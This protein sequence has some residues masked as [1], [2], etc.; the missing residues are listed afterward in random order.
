M[1]KP[2]I[3]KPRVFKLREVFVWRSN[4]LEEESEPY[5]I[6]KEK[7]PF[8]AV[9]EKKPIQRGL[10]RMPAPAHETVINIGKSVSIKGEV[11]GEEDLTIEGRVEGRIKL[12][13]HNLVIGPYG[14]IKGEISARNLTVNGCVAGNISAGH[15]VEIKA[16]GS[17]VGDI[18]ASHISIAEGAHFKGSVDLRKNAGGKAECYSS[19]PV[20]TGA[21]Q[22]ALAEVQAI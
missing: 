16:S 14:T 17:V 10:E 20:F 21:E 3:A 4:K 7:L 8:S 9:E 22:E 6:Q 12:K 1:L 15:L 13:D 5:L 11:T 19:E 2:T 18:E